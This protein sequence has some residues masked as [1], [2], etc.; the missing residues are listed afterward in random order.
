MEIIKVV[1]NNVTKIYIRH[2]KWWEQG[3]WILTHMG[4]WLI[5]DG[6]VDCEDIFK[7]YVWISIQLSFHRH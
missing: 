4:K 3:V 2:I 6:H 7:R 5:L 1:M